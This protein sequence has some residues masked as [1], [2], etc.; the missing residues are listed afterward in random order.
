M[1]DFSLP[2]A[3]GST[4]IGGLAGYIGGILNQDRTRRL[5]RKTFLR[6]LE[7]EVSILQEKLIAEKEFIREFSEK[8]RI[9]VCLRENNAG[10]AL[11]L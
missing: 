8:G 5:E 7:V 4:L 11:P 6:A 1:S 10:R 9:A 2:A 3:L